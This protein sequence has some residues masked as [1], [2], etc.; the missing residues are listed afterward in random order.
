MAAG[1]GGQ[2]VVSEDPSAF[3][4]QLTTMSAFH[5]MQA[6]LYADYSTELEALDLRR[7]AT[8][9]RAAQVLDDYLDLPVTRHGHQSLLA[10]VL[11]LRENLAAYDATYLALTEQVAGELLTADEHLMRG[12]LKHTGLTIARP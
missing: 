4:S 8:E 12:V 10:R 11:D 6:Q 5:D 7:D 1:H 9:E 3:L 2:V